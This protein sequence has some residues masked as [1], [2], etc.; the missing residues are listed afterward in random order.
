MYQNDLAPKEFREKSITPE[1]G[2]K[3]KSHV[4]PAPFLQKH[5]H[6]APNSESI[7]S[8]N[9]QVARIALSSLPTPPHRK[10]GKKAA[11]GVIQES[12]ETKK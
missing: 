10:T 8:E 1:T 5:I 4:L 9:S 3:M 7:Y 11:P 6:P 12:H 2:P